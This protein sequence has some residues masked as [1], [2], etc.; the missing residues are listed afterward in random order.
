MSN[1]SFNNIKPAKAWPTWVC[2]LAFACIACLLEALQLSAILRFEHEHIEQLWRLWTAHW[3]HLSWQHLGLNVMTAVVLQMLLLGAWRGLDWLC[4]WLLIA[5]LVS[6]ALY[7]GQPHLQ[8]YVGMSGLLH[9][10]W[11]IGAWRL[12]GSLSTI[13]V[14]KTFANHALQA[15]NASQ[16]WFG[17][18]LLVLLVSKLAY[19]Q[20][21]GAMPWSETTAG[22]NVIVAAHLYGAVIA[23]VVFTCWALVV[24]IYNYVVTR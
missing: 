12:A 6:L 8:W 17:W 23:A 5:P 16:K 14:A 20:L 11:L 10:V 3:V 1:T 15:K 21:Y 19:E 2:V 4:L 22:G 13:T 18:I 9:G 7:A 24:M